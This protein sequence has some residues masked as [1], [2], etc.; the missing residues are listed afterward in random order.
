MHFWNSSFKHKMK[1]LQIPQKLVHEKFYLHEIAAV[2]LSELYFLKNI[3]KT[4]KPNNRMRSF[5]HKMKRL[6][7]PQKL[8]YKKFYLTRK[9]FYVHKIATVNLSKIYFPKNAKKTCK[10]NNRDL[11]RDWAIIGVSE[12]STIGVL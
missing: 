9:K 1:R 10:P 6:R 11:N 8:V 3:R 12:A 4:C 5:K 7:I 2:N